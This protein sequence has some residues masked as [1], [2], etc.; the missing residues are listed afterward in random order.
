MITEEQSML[1]NKFLHEYYYT[2]LPL[3][4]CWD[5]ENDIA[6]ALFRGKKR[7][8]IDFKALEKFDED[9]DCSLC[10]LILNEEEELEELLSDI[11]D[12][13][14]L[15][16]YEKPEDKRI[17]LPKNSCFFENE[18]IENQAQIEEYDFEVG[19]KNLPVSM[20]VWELININKKN[21]IEVEGTIR[22]M[23]IPTKYV[24]ERTWT[25]TM[26]G[27]GGRCSGVYPVKYKIF[28]R[29]SNKL[30]C[31]QCGKET[32]HQFDSS[33]D[34]IKKAQILELYEKTASA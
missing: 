5:E 13:V 9:N 14:N 4:K 1:F 24:S 31:V 22:E 3:R 20:D 30:M 19:F 32:F 21:I 2:N 8:I 23:S 29:I 25:C 10:K 34:V 17:L 16:E 18:K 26:A 12:E 27:K 15:T 7:I 11:K 28:D 33:D 6:T